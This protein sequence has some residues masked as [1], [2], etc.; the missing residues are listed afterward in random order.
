MKLSTKIQKTFKIQVKTN[1]AIQIIK[2]AHNFETES[3]VIEYLIDVYK[4]TANLKSELDEYKKQ[5]QELIE[6][7]KLLKNQMYF[8][9]KQLEQARAE[10]EQKQLKIFAES[11][12]NDLTS[13]LRG[14][15]IFIASGIVLITVIISYLIRY[16]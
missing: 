8:L 14:E 1:E 4:Y 11:V 15:F 2:E 7:N 13:N 5:N 12:V 6:E 9:E 3:E 10:R 16:L